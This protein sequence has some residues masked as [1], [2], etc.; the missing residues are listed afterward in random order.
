MPGSY[1]WQRTSENVPYAKFAELRK[2]EVRRI[3]LLGTSV[4]RGKNK[5]PGIEIIEGI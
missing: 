2:G 1:S 5:G 3:L 4:N